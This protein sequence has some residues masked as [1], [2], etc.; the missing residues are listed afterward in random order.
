MSHF[1]SLQAANCFQDFPWLLINIVVT[2][3]VAGIVIGNHLVISQTADF[4]LAGV[5]QIENELGVVDDF[6]ITSELGILVL[7][8]IETMGTGGHYFL[9][10]V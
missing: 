5:N 9:D 3:Q 7:E 4:Y 6:I 1:Y 2:S 10:M 8:S